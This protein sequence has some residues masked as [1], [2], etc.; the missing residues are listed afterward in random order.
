[1]GESVIP[2]IITTQ[3]ALENIA[4]ENVKMIYIDPCLVHQNAGDAETIL[5]QH[6]YVFRFR[7]QRGGILYSRPGMENLQPLDPVDIL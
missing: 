3:E 4:E 5:Q 2:V 1:M 6:G 7:T